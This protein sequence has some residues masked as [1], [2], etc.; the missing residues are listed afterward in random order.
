MAW[1]IVP[2]RSASIGSLAVWAVLQFGTPAVAG[3]LDVDAPCG[4]PIC[5]PSGAAAAPAAPAAR[6]TQAPTQA[7]AAARPPVVS[8]QADD[9]SDFPLPQPPAPR[10]QQ[11]RTTQ[12]DRDAARRPRQ[13]IELGLGR[14][15]VVEL[16]K[17]SRDIY[18]SDPDVVEV[19][20]RTQRRLYIAGRKE[21]VTT[22]IVSD[23][24]GVEIARY[25]VRVARDDSALVDALNSAL[26][27]A[28]ITVRA[29]GDTIILQ[30]SVQSA[31]DAEQAVTIATGFVDGEAKRVVN[32][33]TIKA[34]E[35]VQ[36][37]VTVAEVQRNVLK[38]LGISASGNW[39]VGDMTLK[40]VMDNP[41]GV[42]GQALT[43]SGASL[44]GGSGDITIKAM[45]EVGVARTLAEPTVT[46][47][48]GETGELLVG[49]KIPI[50][51]GFSCSTNNVCQPSI[52]FQDY[53]V[54][55]KF[56]PQVLAAG[57]INLKVAA[58]VS[59][60][61]P[62]NKLSIPVSSGSSYS[63]PAF[64]VRK[65]DTVVELPS[66]GA[67]M[68]AGLIQQD[69]RQAIDGVPVAMDV[70]VLGA[71]FRSRDYQRKETELVIIVT[72]VLVRAA[73]PRRLVR[74]DKGFADAPDPRGILF[75]QVNRT[76]GREKTGTPPSYAPFNGHA[77]F[78]LE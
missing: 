20:P 66:G 36:L 46:V 50:P 10:A 29:S 40:A 70:P 16:S 44:S 25:E 2:P 17:P 41:L 15:K 77:G 65:Q 39:Q 64:K 68:T 7:P 37:R 31:A 32:A 21:G 11:Q 61:D 75:G 76:F 59:E 69:S 26:P 27:A 1:L 38:Q 13:V 35:Q 51:T 4:P 18:S 53:G 43:S 74:P 12:R 48:S 30:G 72:P 57:R 24:D 67:L 73:E 9:F 8:T 33:M 78:I 5:A 63:V 42:A 19:L 49:G 28:A 6:R 22:V 55:L 47:T 14:S 23:D 34:K 60:I 52:S 58:E 54:R 3:G 71:L 62:T 45:E 56:A